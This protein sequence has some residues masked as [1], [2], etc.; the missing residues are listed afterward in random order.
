MGAKSRSRFIN[1]A[2]GISEIVISKNGEIAPMKQDI[3][4]MF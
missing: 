4:R 2:I 3:W 1:K